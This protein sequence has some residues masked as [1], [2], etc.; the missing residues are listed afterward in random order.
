M[1]SGQGACELLAAWR[2]AELLAHQA[3]M[4]L[5]QAFVNFARDVG[6]KPSREMENEAFRLRAEAQRLYDR[7]MAAVDLTAARAHQA[8]RRARSSGF[9]ARRPTSLPSPV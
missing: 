2:E 1:A 5:Y 7:A 4:S 8:A 9:A 3:E 6:P